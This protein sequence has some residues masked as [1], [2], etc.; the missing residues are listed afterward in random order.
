MVKHRHKK[1]KKIRKALF[2]IILKRLKIKQRN[3]NKGKFV[4]K[5]SFKK[6]SKDAFHQTLKNIPVSDREAHIGYMIT[7]T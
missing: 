7:Q 5:P 1:E 3:L 2:H 4:L 6:E